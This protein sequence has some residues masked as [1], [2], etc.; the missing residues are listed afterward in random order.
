MIK[1]CFVLSGVIIFYF[2]SLFLYAQQ[3]DKEKVHLKDLAE[4]RGKYIGTAVD[5]MPLVMDKKYTQVLAEEF[6]VVTPENALKF[7][8]TE[9][10]KG[11]YDFRYGDAVVNF[12]LAHHMKIRGHTLVWHEQLPSWLTR[13]K[14]TKE[15]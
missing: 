14:Y 3:E 7:D 1:K 10:Q 6:N 9:P 5:I 15:E 4:A 2:P 8:A 13:N 11:V 12:A